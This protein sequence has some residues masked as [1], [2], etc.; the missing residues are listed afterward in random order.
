VSELENLFL[1]PDRRLSEEAPPANA[2]PSTFIFDPADPTPSIGGPVLMGKC[3]VDDS[4]L[5]ERPDV[6][7]FTGPVLEAPI[8]VLGAP[9]VELAH[10]SDN[11]HADLFVRVSE[12]TAKVARTTSPRTT[13]AS[14]R[15]G[16][17]NSSP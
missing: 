12:V 11:S 6:L 16:R 9:V 1:H 3:V 2:A 8:E 17:G 10:Q 15:H 4:T 5:S 7:S 14:I 13:C